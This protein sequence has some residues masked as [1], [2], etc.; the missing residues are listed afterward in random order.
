MQEWQTK[1]GL[2]REEFEKLVYFVNQSDNPIDSNNRARILGIQT[3]GVQVAPGAIVR[4]S[5]DAS[6][7]KNTFIGLY[8]YVNG[9]IT[10]GANC[11]IG[12]HCSITSNNHIFEAGTQCFSGNKGE[13]IVIGDG[14]WLATAV[15]VT[16]GVAIGRSNLCCAH[17]VVTRST[18]DYAIMA[19]V[20]SRQVGEIDPKTGE[21]RWYNKK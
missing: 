21:Y 1:T 10:I 14:C 5:P 8:T 19:G 11:L 13:P 3:E 16:A 9:R 17:T 20:P 4:L 18:P 15:M 6:I 12:P 2:S 7:G